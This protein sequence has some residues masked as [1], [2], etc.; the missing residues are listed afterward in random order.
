MKKKRS[1]IIKLLALGLIP[2]LLLDLV[3]TMY[4]TIVLQ[5]SM[6]KEIEKSL[7]YVSASLI[8]TYSNLYP[9]DYT[10]DITGGIYKG[11]QA[12]SGDNR[13]LDSIKTSAGFDATL[14]FGD[15]R[16]ITTIKRER[17][18]ARAVASSASKEI[19]ELVGKNGEDF[20]SEDFVIEG[21]SYYAYYTPLKNKDG[22]I[23]GM[24]FAGRTRAEVQATIQ[25]SI[26]RILIISG[27][28][29]LITSI[30]TIVI[31]SRLSKAMKKTKAFLA[32]IA[33]GDLTSE[34]IE[35][36]RKRKD[37][38]GQIYSI[39]VDLQKELSNIVQNIKSSA[40]KLTTSSEE[41]SSMALISDTTIEEVSRAI[42]DISNGAASQATETQVATENI[43]N[44]GNQIDFI[45]QDVEILKNNSDIMAQAEKE[46]AQI[47]IKLNES[48]DMTIESIERIATQT[49][50]TN[51][52]A[53]N[54]QKAVGLIQSIAE[55]T[56]LL[57]LN[58]S[59]EAARAGEAGRGFAVVAEEIRKLADQSRNSANEIESIIKKLLFE[60]NATV[61]VMKE[62]KTNI[63][64]QQERIGETKE[65]FT[66]VGEGIQTSL[67]SV[68]GIRTK[69][70]DLEQ[71]KVVIL[72]VVSTLSAI[73]Q[74]NAAVTQETSASTE[75]LNATV[76][77][78]A[79]SSEDLK[80][81]AHQLEQ[82]LS[83]FKL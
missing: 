21:V 83:I 45:K 11:K 69:V 35:K 43:S 49:D 51:V 20:F 33:Q 48:N 54:I 15:M 47:L 31:S 65:R 29:I 60:S 80:S 8:E 19:F 4:S 6:K 57:S 76:S 78:L 13:L 2:L 26:N 67:V 79:N 82:D 32:N 53:K 70:N 25:K 28:F 14:Y 58:A 3:I 27:L 30:I 81:L 34:S 72:D 23:I 73:S 62:V 41:L 36:Y 42:V 66:A 50:L 77:K 71:S 1:I 12:I 40:N 56:D 64:T 16:T 61:E 22:S 59:I 74:E 5:D 17:D 39:S 68:D 10:K 38:I 55:E 75:E 46:S 24:I 37:E 9:G 18:G 63:A 44:I 7:R 52:S